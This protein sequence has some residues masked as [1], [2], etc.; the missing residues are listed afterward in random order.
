MGSW[1]LLPIL[2]QLFLGAYLKLHIHE[3]TLRP[4]AV[5]AHGVIGRLWPILGWV[6]GLFGVIVLRGL[7]G[8]EGAGQCAAHYIMVG[9]FSSLVWYG[10]GAKASL[11]KRFYCIRY[12]LSRAATR[13]GKLDTPEWK[14]PRMVGLMGD[15]AMGLFLVVVMK[16]YHLIL[17][18]RRVL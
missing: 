7:C 5:R 17:T 10:R 8:E 4:Y 16:N 12:Y 1:L 11:G 14:K 15:H 13:W 9:A 3:R 2:A 18:H 6:Q